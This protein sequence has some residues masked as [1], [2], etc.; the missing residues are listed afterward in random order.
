MLRL[1]HLISRDAPL[2]GDYSQVEILKTNDIQKGDSSNNS[3]LSLSSHSGTHIDAPFHFDSRGKTLDTYQPE[4]W[5][6][7]RP[8][9]IERKISPEEMITC[10]SWQSELSS[11]P[12]T[13]DILLIK[14][15]FER[16]R[17][18]DNREVYIFNGPGIAPE[19]G[20]WLRRNRSIKYIGFDF[21]SLTSFQNREL[22]RIAHRAFLSAQPDGF[23]SVFDNPPIL[24][25]EDMKLSELTTSPKRVIV[26]PILF[27]N[28]DGAP[29]TVFAEI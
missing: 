13:A 28:A 21:I 7:E 15:G 26:S 1:S 17:N 14:T 19:V 24:I 5:L 27:E 10:D 18:P 25:I 16:F 22:G 9:L 3:S 4:F 23:T 2:Y 29:V 20:L 8:Y 12:A 11:I 6:A